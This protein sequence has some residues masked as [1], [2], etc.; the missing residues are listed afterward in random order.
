MAKSKR[1]RK[2]NGEHETKDPPADVNGGSRRSKLPEGLN[3]LVAEAKRR[4][5]LYGI[6]HRKKIAYLAA[7]SHTGNVTLSARMAGISR[8]TVY[9]WRGNPKEGE[10][11]LEAEAVARES[12]T[13]LLEQEAWRRAHDGV[14]EPVGWYKGAPGGHILRYSDNLLMFLLKSLRPDKYRERHEFSGPEGGPI[15]VMVVRRET[16]E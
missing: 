6:K 15:P 10:A 3:E 1:D 11:F 7:F 12:A 2:P 5:A 13:E 14:E 9:N 8:I 4:G 16:E